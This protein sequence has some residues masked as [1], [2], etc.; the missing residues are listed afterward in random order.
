MNT[1]TLSDLALL[2]LTVV[3][4]IDL[5]GF[6]PSWTSALSKWLDRKIKPERLK[7][8]TC[9]LCMT[10]WTSLAYL[11]ITGAFDI[12]GL[13]VAAILSFLSPLLASALAAFRDLAETI[14]VKPFQFLTRLISKL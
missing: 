12:C 5:S 11:F 1:S 13:A 8:L 7:P 9:S 10:W 4:I 3:Y 6:T 14:I 2:W